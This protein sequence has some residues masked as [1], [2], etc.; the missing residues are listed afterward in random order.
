MCSALRDCIPC[1][2]FDRSLEMKIR[3]TTQADHLLSQEFTPTKEGDKTILWGRYKYAILSY[4]Y[5]S[6]PSR[7]CS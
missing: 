7:K 5:F 4:P 1:Y 6:I 2:T 3:K